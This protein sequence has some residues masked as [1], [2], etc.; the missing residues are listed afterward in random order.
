MIKYVILLSSYFQLCK[1]SAFC[2]LCVVGADCEEDNEDENIFFL[3]NMNDLDWRFHARYTQRF[4]AIKSQ[5][6]ISNIY[7][8]LK[9]T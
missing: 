8:M 2:L 9:I 4:M 7:R 3:A 1:T 6:S 5:S